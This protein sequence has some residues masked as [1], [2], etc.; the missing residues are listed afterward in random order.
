MLVAA[1]GAGVGGSRGGFGVLT[2]LLVQGMQPCEASGGAIQVEV[3]IPI[4]D[5]RGGRGG[6]ASNSTEEVGATSRD[7]GHKRACWPSAIPGAAKE[8][9]RKELRW[10]Q[11]DPGHRDVLDSGGGRIQVSTS[12]RPS[13]STHPECGSS[14]A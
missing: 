4:S 3:T 8:P 9:S 11:L 14:A 10:R 13:L 6:R 1:N 5:G 2:G 12:L 7:R